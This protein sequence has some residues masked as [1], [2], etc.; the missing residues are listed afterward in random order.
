MTIKWA[1]GI[2]HRLFL[3]LFSPHLNKYPRQHHGTRMSHTLSS[4]LI[5]IFDFLTS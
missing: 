4:H 2:S 5:G 1:C 3:I